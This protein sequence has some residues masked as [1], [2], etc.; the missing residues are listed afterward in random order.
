MEKIDKKIVLE[1]LQQ[2]QNQLLKQVEELKE[3]TKPEAPDCAIGRVSR[4]DAINNRSINEA[5]LRKKQNQL[6]KI[7]KALNEINEPN[8]GQCRKC[9]RTIQPQR[10][11]LMPESKLCVNC[12]KL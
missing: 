2:K 12:A 3:L 7:E 11:M 10:I 9:G 1:M 4:M 6:N 5:A 8:F